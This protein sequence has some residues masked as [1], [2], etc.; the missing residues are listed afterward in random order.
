LLPRASAEPLAVKASLGLATGD[1]AGAIEEPGVGGTVRSRPLGHRPL[2]VWS[3][4][5]DAW[6]VGE[7]GSALF[8][9]GAAPWREMGPRTAGAMLA[10]WQAPGG[11]VW[12]G[13][14]RGARPG[15]D[16]HAPEWRA[17]GP[18]AVHA[19]W[20]SADDDVWAAGED[21]LAHFDGERWI[22]LQSDF[23]LERRHYDSTSIAIE[24]RRARI[25]ALWG[26]GA[27]D[28]WAVGRTL[29]PA[30]QKAV[31]FHFDGEAWTEVP[32]C[33][34]APETRG[35]LYAVWGRGPD[36]VWA[37]GQSGALLH[38]DGRAFAPVRSGSNVDL[39]SIAG[40]GGRDVWVGAANG[41][42][43]LMRAPA[44]P[45]GAVP[46][47][48]CD[49][50]KPW[51]RHPPPGAVEMIVAAH[52]REWRRCFAGGRT[53]TLDVDVDVERDG[54]IFV[55]PS[56]GRAATPVDRCVAD[57]M[58]GVR[59]PASA[60]ERPGLLAYRLSAA[61]ATACPVQVTP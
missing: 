8:S 18:R 3:D 6:V 10:V 60:F 28:V 20:G 42:V 52:K 56:G 24:G 26:S 25:Y 1:H 27:R 51:E 43:K 4:G 19:Y 49:M 39:V 33:H 12:A 38:W 46:A 47:A 59:L 53:A 44:P 48:A 32:T 2:G 37:A 35:P 22:T 15:A 13:G 54:R 31:V 50:P 58:R 36:D 9:D 30:P 29:T 55:T 23:V 34:L 16:G 14:M 5:R 57:V 7:H 61:P 21:G 40:A 45:A 41:D 11:D 17:C